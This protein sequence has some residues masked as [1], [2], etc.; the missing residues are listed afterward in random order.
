MILLKKF[1]KIIN[2]IFVF[3]LTNYTM[4]LNSLLEIKLKNDLLSM[5][6]DI[7]ELSLKN[8]IEILIDEKIKVN[9]ITI[10]KSHIKILCENQCCARSMGPRYSDIRCPRPCYKD[11]DYCKLHNKRLEEYDYLLFGRY[12]EPRPIL[13]E[14]GNKIPWRDNTA[15]QDINTLIE[16]QHI[17]LQKLIQ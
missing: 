15:M 13:N 5:F 12:D 8:R 2:L 16:Y 10:D 11:T 6:N 1:V 17:N 4:N 3:L 9:K 14:K 7:T